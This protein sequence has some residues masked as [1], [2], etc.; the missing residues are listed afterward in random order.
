MDV[1][2]LKNHLS[3]FDRFRSHIKSRRSL[4][5]CII[6]KN[7]IYTNSLFIKRDVSRGLIK[8]SLFVLL[9]PPKVYYVV[10][11]KTPFAP[12]LR[13]R[14]GDT[15]VD[16]LS[17]ITNGAIDAFNVSLT[18]NARSHT[19]ANLATAGYRCMR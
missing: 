1:H 11:M 15:L 5:S 18:I 4:L 12:R 8:I 9:N 13:Y 14:K 19:R 17:C 16:K 2:F 7:E 6:S 3:A 10:F